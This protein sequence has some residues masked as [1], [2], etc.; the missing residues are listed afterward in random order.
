MNIG[1]QI[2]TVLVFTVFAS[3]SSL[4][5]CKLAINA[6]GGIMLVGSSVAVFENFG[7]DYTFVLTKEELKKADTTVGN[8]EAFRAVSGEAYADKCYHYMSP[9]Q[10]AKCSKVPVFQLFL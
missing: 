5:A 8:L 7:Y 6:V 4:F 9:L 10:K 2:I 3:S 1:F